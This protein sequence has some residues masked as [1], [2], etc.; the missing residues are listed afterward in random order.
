M[1]NSDRKFKIWQYSVSHGMLLL[2]SPIDGVHH[3]N[4]DV[5]FA[6]VSYINLPAVMN[7]MEVI[8]ASLPISEVWPMAKMGDVLYTVRSQGMEYFVVGGVC[9]SYENKLDLFETGF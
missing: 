5:V 4:M 3:M 2:R 7:G 9:R 8:V 6:G 1:I